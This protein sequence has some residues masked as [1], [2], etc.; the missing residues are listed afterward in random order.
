MYARIVDKVSRTSKSM[1]H[2]CKE[3]K[4]TKKQPNKHSKFQ[5]MLDAEMDNLKN[6]K[7]NN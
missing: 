7:Y 6:K 3:E 2:L 4:S 1:N 5:S